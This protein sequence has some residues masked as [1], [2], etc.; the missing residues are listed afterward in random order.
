MDEEISPE[1]AERCLLS[2]SLR[3]ENVD[4]SVFFKKKKKTEIIAAARHGA[5]FFPK[6]EIEI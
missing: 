6:S 5:M 3:A 4:I 1:L 2:S